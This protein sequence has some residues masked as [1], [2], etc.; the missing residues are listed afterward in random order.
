M[1]IRWGIVL[2]PLVLCACSGN[3]NQDLRD[4]MAQES[5]NMRGH[6]QPLAKVDLPEV[7]G[8]DAMALVDPFQSRRIEPEKAAGNGMRPD[9]N[10]RREPLEAFP[11]ESL[12]MVGMMMMQ[13]KPVALVQADKTIYQV[14]AGNYLGQNFGVVTKI[15]DAELSLK[16]LIE[17]AN[18][19]WVERITTMQLQEQETKK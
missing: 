7:P 9:T 19:D 10:R 14:K 12:K 3:G 11:I 2:V 18:G 5:A 15:T 8:Y 16:E 17:D 13:S 6:I 1:T 4:W